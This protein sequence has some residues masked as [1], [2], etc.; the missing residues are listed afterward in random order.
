MAWRSR[1]S[2]ELVLR[3]LLLGSMFM[4]IYF[5]IA[6]IYFM[7]F[8]LSYFGM[9]ALEDPRKKILRLM[10]GVPNRVFIPSLLWPI[11]AIP[12]FCS[13]LKLRR[14]MRR[15]ELEI[16]RNESRMPSWEEI[17]KELKKREMQ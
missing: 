1:K 2:V 5:F 17:Q 6:A 15:A 7:G 3:V 12:F 13:A 14:S 4:K 9:I 16:E 11:T 10:S 8:F